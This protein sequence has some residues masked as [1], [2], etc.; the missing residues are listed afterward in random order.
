[1]RIRSSLPASISRQPATDPGTRCPV[2]LPGFLD[3]ARMA[4][5]AKR[6]CGD[7]SSRT[8]RR[9]CHR[10]YLQ[11][12]RCGNP[13]HIRGDRSTLVRWLGAS[14]TCGQISSHNWLLKQNGQLIGY[15][16]AAPWKTRSA[17]RFR[18]KSPYMSPQATYATGLVRCS[19]VIS[20]RSYRRQHRSS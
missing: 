14:R 15:A 7:S 17:Y 9:Q 18:W 3:V 12:L 6:D 1:M 2:P 4:A 13:H 20:S 19:T 5:N 16:H 11:P 10:H 8:I